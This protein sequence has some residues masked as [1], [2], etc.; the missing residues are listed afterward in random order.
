MV[1][2]GRETGSGVWGVWGVWGVSV[3]WGV[4][5]VSGV[6]VVSGVSGF[7]AVWVASG[8]SEV[9]GVWAASGV[10]EVSGVWAASVVLGVSVRSSDV[11]RRVRRGLAPVVRSSPLPRG[12][13][14][15]GGQQDRPSAH[16]GGRRAPPHR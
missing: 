14:A 1:H 2:D 7:S 16:H 15:A 13:G 12:P 9:S 5:G 3:V 11:A 8:V 4:W 6:W 10:S